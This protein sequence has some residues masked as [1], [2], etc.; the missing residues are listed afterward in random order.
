MYAGQIVEEGPVAELFASPRH[1]Y[2]EGLLGCIPVPG[3]TP[4]GEA[5]G[6]IPG[7]VPALVGDLQ[8]CAFF[9]RCPHAQERCRQTVPVHGAETGQRW[10]CVLHPEGALA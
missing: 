10:R 1:P 9:D 5:L 7:V 2:T 4:P 3:R 8:G 6:T